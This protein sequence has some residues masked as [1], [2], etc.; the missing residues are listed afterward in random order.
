MNSNPVDIDGAHF[1]SHQL[2][3]LEKRNQSQIAVSHIF[4]V[5]VGCV[6]GHNSV[7]LNLINSS[8]GN[9]FELC[10]CGC[11]FAGYPD[12][13]RVIAATKEVISDSL[14]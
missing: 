14:L 2:A 3:I 4:F 11:F 10:V 9:G 1:F 5:G 12:P 6:R 7:Q 13:N 8:N